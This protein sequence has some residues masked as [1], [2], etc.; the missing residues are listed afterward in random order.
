MPDDQ[1][2]ERDP[3]LAAGLRRVAPEVDT[4]AG[5]AAVHDRA[6][7][8]HRRG[9]VVLAAASLAVVALIAGMVVIATEDEDQADSVDAGPSLA[10]DD[11]ALTPD[12]SRQRALAAATE[13]AGDEAL[14]RIEARLTTRGEA[15]Q[16]LAS[17]D[18][19][20]PSLDPTAAE[21]L[22][23]LVLVTPSWPM[24]NPAAWQIVAVGADSPTAAVLTSGVDEAGFAGA[25]PWWGSVWDRS[26]PQLC[27]SGEA[28]PVTPTTLV[29]D[30]PRTYFF[31]EVVLDPP[32]DDRE[33][34]DHDMAA[35]LLDRVPGTQGLWE[36][37]LADYKELPPRAEF[38]EDEHPSRPA[39]V[40]IG[41]RVG[42]P[43]PGRP[44][45]CLWHTEIHAVDAETG[46][47]LGSRVEVHP[48][49]LAAAEDAASSEETLPSETGDL[50]PTEDITVSNQYA[51]TIVRH[52][53]DILM[54]DGL[55]TDDGR[56]PWAPDAD[57]RTRA[58]LISADDPTVARTIDLGDMGPRMYVEAWWWNGEWGIAGEQC[59]EP[60]NDREIDAEYLE[61]GDLLMPEH[62]GS[63]TVDVFA[64][65]PD[66]GSVRTVVTGIDRGE[67]DP[68]R[69]SVRPI[70]VAGS[71]AM[72]GWS[73]GVQHVV[74][75]DGT[76]VDIDSIGNRAVLAADG[77][78][79]SLGPSEAGSEANGSPEAEPRPLDELWELG[80][81]DG[82]TWEPVPLPDSPYE[83]YWPNGALAGDR[84][85][86]A[87]GHV[88]SGIGPIATLHL[89]RVLDAGSGEMMWDTVPMEAPLPDGIGRGDPDVVDGQLVSG[90][91]RWNGDAWVDLPGVRQMFVGDSVFVEDL[92]G[93]LGFEPIGE[94]GWQRLR[95]TLWKAEELPG[96]DI[97]LASDVSLPPPPDGYVHITLPVLHDLPVPTGPADLWAWQ[98]VRDPAEPDLPVAPAWQGKLHLAPM[99]HLDLQEELDDDLIASH[100][101]FE[102]TAAEAAELEALPPETI[103]A[104]TPDLTEEMIRSCYATRGPCGYSPEFR[105][106]PT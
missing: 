2:P 33:A 94:Y 71:R 91:H 26:L 62:C 27:T 42:G 83:Y 41:E 88:G 9:R 75:L 70:A 106:P 86:V 73:D 8:G 61:L 14:G 23:W 58:W 65:D 50:V 15:V 80:R 24:G 5:L 92:G 52:G 18:T 20:A 56:D 60:W 43:V 31:D 55:A 28:P 98:A 78:F 49:A 54:V 17:Y 44:D 105:P 22:L 97:P 37:R 76:V 3:V 90:E 40:L 66:D 36:L 19:P 11:G 103:F 34:D 51:S 48:F 101:T 35:P 10:F 64:V 95:V 39:W 96:P 12:V 59:P 13:V 74:D 7:A 79:L 84:S 25:P 100:A 87:A 6:L 67:D 46:E 69:G 68:N 85:F 99:V 72:L 32:A 38:V 4:E 81:L 63:T 93:S 57:P 45:D 16:H 29:L 77:E 47:P 30:A 82:T 89:L 104:I 102:V 1:V 53:D 21:E